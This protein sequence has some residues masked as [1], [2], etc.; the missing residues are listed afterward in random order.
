[1]CKNRGKYLFGLRIIAENKKKN[2]KCE[3]LL[4]CTFWSL[5]LLLFWLPIF[6]SHES[7]TQ[8]QC[9]IHSTADLHHFGSQRCLEGEIHVLCVSQAQTSVLIYSPHKDIPIRVDCTHVADATVNSRHHAIPVEVIPTK[10]SSWD[11]FGRQNTF[12]LR[13]KT[14]YSI[15]PNKNITMICGENRRQDRQ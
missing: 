6:L 7:F 2:I 10:Q 13:S 4:P 11:L 9:M 5:G 3:G 12:G 14:K 8:S 1:M 15:A